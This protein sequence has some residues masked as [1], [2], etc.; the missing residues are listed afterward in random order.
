MANLRQILNGF[1]DTTMFLSLVLW[2]CITPF[3]LLFTV[4][5]FGWQSS[6]TVAILLFFIA[7]ALCW[8]VCI[9][10]KISMEEK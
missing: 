1:H 8:G 5:F 10:P 3:V 7:L 9:F 2:L 6:V 4:P